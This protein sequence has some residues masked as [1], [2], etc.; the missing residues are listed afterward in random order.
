MAEITSRRRGELVRGVFE[1]L[2]DKPDGLPAAQV[3]KAVEQ[4]VPPSEFE[5]E[6]YERNPSVRRYEKTIRFS[7]ITSVKAGWL[8][9]SGGT[10]SLTEEG[11]QAYQSFTDPEAFEREA[12][13]GYRAWAKE[14]QPSQPEI[15]QA[16]D[17]TESTGTLEEAEDAAWAEIRTYLTTMPPYDFQRLVAALLKAMGYY[18]D[19]IAP[20]GPD[21]GIDLIAHPDPLGTT[22][23][24]IKVQVKRRDTEK[25]SAESLRAFMAVVGDQDVGIYI[26]AAGFSQ[27]AERE[28][29]SQEKRRLKLIDLEDFVELWVQNMQTLPDLD[30]RRLPLK[31]IYFLASA[32]E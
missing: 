14:R 16:S 17:V 3:L 13:R 26:S 5:R 27:P 21:G 24:R 4:L 20:P 10:W 9:K 28:A 19:W 15:E 23:P 8:V 18:V 22:G 7:T 2:M 30:R 29:R 11:R 12:V 31:P 25:V 1:V 32:P 6:T